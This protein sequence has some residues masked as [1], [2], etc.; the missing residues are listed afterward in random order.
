M[1]NS[2][3]ESATEI[4]WDKFESTYYWIIYLDNKNPLNSAT[5][6][7]M[8]GYSKVVGHDE[9]R[10]KM[11]LL[12]SKVSMLVNRGYP[13]RST[14]IEIYWKQ[15][16]L[17][18]KRND[19]I[20]LTLY[21][22]DYQFEKRCL[23]PKYYHVREFLRK[24]Y[25]LIIVEDGTRGY[26]SNIPPGSSKDED[27]NPNRF[28]FR[29]RRDLDEYCSKMLRNGRARGQVEGFRETYLRTHF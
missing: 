11:Q 5:I 20:L 14:R 4:D 22:D 21:P 10:D 28:S 7:P 16:R 24:I 23:Q 17:I 27:L 13:F 25:S 3:K 1:K 2:G 29:R 15:G 6:K 8:T 19:P 18:D 12:M 9:A 26:T